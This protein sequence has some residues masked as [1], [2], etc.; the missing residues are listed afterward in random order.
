[1]AQRYKNEKYLYVVPVTLKCTQTY[2]KYPNT[3]ADVSTWNHM[4]SVKDIKPQKCGRTQFQIF[5]LQ[6]ETQKYTYTGTHV[7]RKKLHIVHS[8]SQLTNGSTHTCAHQSQD[9]DLDGGS[10][11]LPFICFT[12]SFIASKHCLFSV[13]RE[14]YTVSSCWHLAL[15]A[16]CLSAARGDELHVKDSAYELLMVR[17]KRARTHCGACLFYLDVII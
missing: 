5:Y 12:F 10:I 15:P 1:M 7:H 2:I 4:H 16:L 14:R 8:Y 17:I 9:D 13:D 11:S 6:K 3:E